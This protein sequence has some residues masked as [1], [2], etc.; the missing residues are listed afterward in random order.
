MFDRK[1][2]AAFVILC[3]SLLVCGLGFRAAVGFLRI[4][5][6][7]R[8]VELREHFAA[9]PRSLGQ[10]QAV[11]EDVV[12]DTATVE[13]LGTTQYLDRTYV[14]ELGPGKRDI[15]QL[16][17]AYYTGMIDAVPHV[18]DRCME[19][20]GMDQHSLPRNLPLDINYSKWPRNPSTIHKITG[21]PYPTYMYAHHITGQPIRVHLP[22][23]DLQ[24]RV[25]EFGDP[26]NPNA[27]IFAG[28]FFIA[29]GATTPI[30]WGVK[31][32]AFDPRQEYAYY[33]KVQFTMVGDES[34]GQSRFLDA[35][36]DLTQEMLP[37][38]M[39][40]LPDWAEVER[41]VQE[42]DSNASMAKDGV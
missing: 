26:N 16:H 5:L 24:L 2:K 14:R 19:A 13:S 4:S 17:F 28:Y 27:K 31:R 41:R 6:A 35:A 22:I 42:P 40:C 12:L 23:G 32:L 11:G 36:S 30:P 7:K 37:R 38:L 39:Y 25:T 29:N 21:E 15:M 10:W 3:I 9:V 34:L 18:P 20:H 33:C 1:A 8:P